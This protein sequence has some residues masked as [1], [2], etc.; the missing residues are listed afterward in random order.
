MEQVM[1]L[2]EEQ[3]RQIGNYVSRNFDELIERSRYAQSRS[4]EISVIERITRVEEELK[5]QREIMMFGF[6]QIDKRFEAMQKSMDDGF[7]AVGTRF[8]DVNRR[9]TMLM[10]AIGVG[11]T[12]TTTAISIVSVL[13]R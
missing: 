4:H 9:F 3:L 5:S 11:F 12:L 7:R 2:T 8:D 6:Q 1:E 13:T 10:W